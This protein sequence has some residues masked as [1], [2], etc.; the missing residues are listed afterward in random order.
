[1]YELGL[2]T[3]N[4][5]INI[6]I[7]KTEIPKNFNSVQHRISND[8]VS[9]SLII[10]LGCMDEYG[11]P[12]L[13]SLMNRVYQ[14]YNICYKIFKDFEVCVSDYN[15][16]MRVFPSS[17]IDIKGLIDSS[18]TIYERF[19]KLLEEVDKNAVI[20]TKMTLNIYT[21]KDIEYTHGE[22]SC[23]PENIS[24]IP[25][26]NTISKR[27]IDNNDESITFMLSF[28]YKYN[29]LSAILFNIFKISPLNNKF[30]RDIDFDIK[31]Y[32]LGSEKTFVIFV[33]SYMILNIEEYIKRLK[34][35]IIDNYY[36]AKNYNLYYY[37]NVEDLYNF[38]KNF[39]FLSDMNKSYYQYIEEFMYL[40]FEKIINNLFETYKVNTMDISYNPNKFDIDKYIK[41][42]EKLK[43]MKEG[44]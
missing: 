21:D 16:Y 13:I 18:H 31:L 39:G 5:N 40:D 8:I 14:K 43:E 42:N 27:E 2:K 20:L 12:E 23:V 22:I 11:I 34:F 15:F 32:M 37:L 44:F 24:L 41:S 3:L 26:L 6:N 7:R 33:S 19:I 28:D 29:Y 1:M 25:L 36:Y 10:H 17:V 38:C 30:K 35:H 9:Y 4:K